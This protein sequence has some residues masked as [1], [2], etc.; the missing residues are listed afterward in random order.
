[1]EHRSVE[2]G[3]LVGQPT[4]SRSASALWVRHVGRSSIVRSLVAALGEE[5]FQQERDS[6]AARDHGK[7]SR[8]PLPGITG[9]E[10]CR[11]AVSGSV[12]NGGNLAGHGKPDVGADSP[13]LSP[14][15]ER[16]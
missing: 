1:V 3:D 10:G 12:V 15:G 9:R 2:T 14:S 8:H 6:V 13:T 7:D 5:A 16:N 11:D 4:I